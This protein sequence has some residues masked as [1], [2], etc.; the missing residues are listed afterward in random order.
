MGHSTTRLLP[1]I[2]YF[3]LFLHVRQKNIR[4]IISHRRC[5]PV[6]RVIFDPV[7]VTC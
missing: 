4:L 1:Y 2:T 5:C 7:F 6:L 3:K